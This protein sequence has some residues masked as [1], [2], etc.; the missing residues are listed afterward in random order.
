MRPCSEFSMGIKPRST[1][2]SRSAAKA[3]SNVGAAMGSQCGSASRAAAWEN[4]PGSP[5]KTTRRA[6][7]IREIS[8]ISFLGNKFPR[9]GQILRS[10]DGERHHVNLRHFDAHACFQRAQLLQLLALL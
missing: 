8:L 3:S 4:D 7:S 5:W 9:A 6:F 2:P 10:V 1:V